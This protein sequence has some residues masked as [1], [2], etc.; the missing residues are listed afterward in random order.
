M[1]PTKQLPSIF[2]G[3]KQREVQAADRQSRDQLRRQPGF[4]GRRGGPVA[5]AANDRRRKRIC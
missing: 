4:H 5:L 3:A 1:H 2:S